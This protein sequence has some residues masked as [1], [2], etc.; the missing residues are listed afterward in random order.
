MSLNTNNSLDEELDQN[1]IYLK[2]KK[3]NFIAFNRLKNAEL[4]KRFKTVQA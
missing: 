3:F 2:Y 4:F 1:C